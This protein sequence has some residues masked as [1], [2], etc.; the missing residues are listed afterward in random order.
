MVKVYNYFL[1][2]LDLYI[3]V[4]VCICICMYVCMHGWMTTIY[5]CMHAWMN[6]H[7]TCMYACMCGWITTIYACM[8]ACMDKWPHSQ[9]GTDFFST[10]KMLSSLYYIHKGIFHL[11]SFFPISLTH[12][13]WNNSYFGLAGFPLCYGCISNQGYNLCSDIWVIP[14]AFMHLGFL[15]QLFFP[16]F[17]FLQISLKLYLFGKMNFVLIDNQ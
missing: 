4:H 17:N 5:V 7:S 1:L 11:L 10:V 13:P 15:L 14:Q 8:H 9:L 16:L 2:N 12:F 3:F 6:G